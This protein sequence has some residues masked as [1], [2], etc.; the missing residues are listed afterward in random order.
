MQGKLRLSD[1]KR[2]CDEKIFER[3]DDYYEAGRVR[4]RLR[5]GKLITAEVI[6][7]AAYQVSVYLSGNKVEASC[8][9]PYD[10]GG[11]CKHIIA[12]LLALTKEPESFRDLSNI[13]SLL[14][15][16][17]KDE[18][19]E[20][21]LNIASVQPELIEDLGLDLEENEEYD[22]IR[23]VCNIFDSFEIAEDLDISDL[24]KRLQVIAGK[25]KGLQEK[26]KFDLARGIYFEIL[27]GC[28]EIEDM[29]GSGE[30]FPDSFIVDMVEQY[31]SIALSD[32]DFDKKKSVI[33][34]EVDKLLKY[35]ASEFI[36]IQLEELITDLDA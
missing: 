34:K 8:S 25:A 32:D 35:E 13:R 5:K 33:Q 22:G 29:Y 26:G 16:K 36:E 19:I 2:L 7:T 31:Q 17:H 3:G 23:A 18:L 28:L 27:K 9:C 11:Y 10:W 20:T 4:N 30:I 15:K 14:N 6:G 12:T 21:I 24:I 1:I